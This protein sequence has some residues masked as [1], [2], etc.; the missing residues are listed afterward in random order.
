MLFIQDV[1]VKTAYISYHCQGF[2]LILYELLLYFWL[3]YEDPCTVGLKGGVT[4]FKWSSNHVGCVVL[5]TSELFQKKRSYLV[6]NNTND[7][8]VLCIKKHN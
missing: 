8:T 7:Y 4:L 3:Y 5:A 6:Q 2:V 1:A